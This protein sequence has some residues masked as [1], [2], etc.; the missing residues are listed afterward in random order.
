MIKE[1]LIYSIKQFIDKKDI[2]IK[3][4]QRIEDLLDDLKPEKE[5]INN[6]IL[7][8]ASYVCGGGVYMYD[9]DKV[10]L[11]FKKKILIF[12]NDA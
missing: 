10:I 5:L 6:M 2:S 12:L 1:K 7:I 9:E 8:L 3:N 4:A 11:E